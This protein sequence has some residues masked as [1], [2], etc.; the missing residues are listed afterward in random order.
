MNEKIKSFREKDTGKIQNLRIYSAVA[1]AKRED[2]DE[3][4]RKCWDTGVY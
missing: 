4:S 1:E 3:G 2:S